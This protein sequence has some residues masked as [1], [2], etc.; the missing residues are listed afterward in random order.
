MFCDCHIH[1]LMNAQN[2]GEAVAVH[3][4]GVNDKDIQGKL[5]AYKEEG[6][7]YLRDGGDALGV[8]A[9]AKALAPA[10]GITY[11]TPIFA[12][13]KN[14]HY[15]SIVGLGFEDM[16]EY[17]KLVK[18]AGEA[19]ADF[20]KIMV[21]GIM[22]FAKDG[23]L[24]EPSLTKEEMRQMIHIAHEEGFAVMAHVNGARA[25]LDVI[26][27]GVDSVE[28]GNFIDDDGLQALKESEAVW[29]PTFVTITNLVGSGRYD[30]DKILRLKKRQG[31][32]IRKGFALGVPIAP[33]SDAGAFRVLHAKGSRDEYRE[34]Y[35]LCKDLMSPEEF[36]KRLDCAAKKI[37]R[38]FHR[39]S[40]NL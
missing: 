29:V 19:G 14:G 35:E 11:R 34:L 25:I 26:E 17:R 4:D 33:G 31:E 5:L 37:Q 10:Y 32:R 6:I 24:T 2:Y 7:T 8:S 39:E 15:G 9:R 38:R 22:D 12:I 27:A 3:K 18:K 30:D 13:H 28:H 16:A 23:A 40:L 21:S 1:M 36:R 20:I